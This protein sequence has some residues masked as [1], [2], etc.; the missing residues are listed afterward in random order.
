MGRITGWASGQQWKLRTA[1][2]VLSTEGGDAADPEV[3]DDS[4]TIIEADTSGANAEF[5]LPA[6][7]SR[8]LD[9]R[10]TFVI[11]TAGNDIVVQSVAG[12]EII[13]GSQTLSGAV[14]SSISFTSNG[15]DS[16][17]VVSSSS[18]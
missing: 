2:G 13:G 3:L 10:V 18:L 16:W 12:A 6:P 15:S 17:I 1:D 5:V 14:G 8:N 9:A 11:A 4:N 7:S